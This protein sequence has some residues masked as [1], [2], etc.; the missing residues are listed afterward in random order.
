[1]GY[2]A[3]TGRGCSTYVR[4]GISLGG[5]AW[6]TLFPE[7]LRNQGGG[8]R[9]MRDRGPNMTEGIVDGHVSFVIRKC[10]ALDGLPFLPP[11]HFDC[12]TLADV[13]EIRL[14]RN[15]LS[16]RLMPLPQWYA[17]VKRMM[18]ETAITSEVC[19][20]IARDINLTYA[21]VSRAMRKS[22]ADTRLSP[23]VV[24]ARRTARLCVISCQH[25]IIV[26]A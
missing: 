20:R 15:W 16:M 22:D 2:S 26:S 4:P 13:P 7:K 5:S 21:Q 14:T 17:L 8:M 9:W 18:V 11:S 12:S 3:V 24:N 23:F 6:Q 10:N 19:Q 1:M 25:N